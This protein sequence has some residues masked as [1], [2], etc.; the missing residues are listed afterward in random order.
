VNLPQIDAQDPMLDP[1]KVEFEIQC[2]IGFP[3]SDGG[4]KKGSL[5]GAK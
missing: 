2:A 3:P 5:S 4:V 1:S